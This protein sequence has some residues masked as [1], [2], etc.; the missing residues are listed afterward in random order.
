[1]E[2]SSALHILTNGAIGLKFL[3]GADSSSLHMQVQKH[4]LSNLGKK[5]P[6]NVQHLK[7]VV[8]EIHISIKVQISTRK[9]LK[10]EDI[11][12]VPVLLRLE[13]FKVLLFKTGGLEDPVGCGNRNR[14]TAL[15]LS[16]HSLYKD[17]KCQVI[18]YVRNCAVEGFF[19]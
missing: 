11:S 15:L 18:C 13:A 16:D 10:Y 17:I 9:V 19:R 1:M 2:I 14:K 6:K 7:A 3:R 12:D 5:S 4:G 8:G